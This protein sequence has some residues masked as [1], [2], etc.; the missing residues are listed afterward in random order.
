VGS[1]I[2]RYHRPRPVVTVGLYSK[3]SLPAS[4]SRMA[5][6]TGRHGDDGSRG[7]DT[8]RVSLR[9][10]CPPTDGANPLLVA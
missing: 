2:P 9:A 8:R 1:K 7:R 4:P 10:P 3:Q 5:V 6:R